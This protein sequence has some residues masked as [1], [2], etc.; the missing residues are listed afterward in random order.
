MR[1]FLLGLL[2]GLSFVMAAKPQA[3]N[4]RETLSIGAANLSLGMS[5]DTAIKTLAEHSYTTRKVEPPKQLRDEGV[6]SLWIVDSKDERGKEISLGN[7]NFASGKLNFAQKDLLGMDEDAVSFG[8][9]LYFALR[10]LEDEGDSHCLIET[11]T[12]KIPE[13]AHTTANLRC[14]KKSIV[15]DL[16]K[17][18]KQ[19]ES[20]QLNE[21]L[22]R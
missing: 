5:E 6:T 8:R 18:Q 21:E 2:I 3:A 1:T 4:Y 16:Q 10:E 17:F 19:D 13:Y 11:K 12:A 14:G 22:S 15:I 7:L 9:Q 20:V